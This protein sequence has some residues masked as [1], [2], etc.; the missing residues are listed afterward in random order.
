GRISRNPHRSSAQHP[1]V[2]GPGVSVP[3]RQRR[4]RGWQ[5]STQLP[6]AT[7]GQVRAALGRD[8]GA[9]R[10]AVIGVVLV[11]GLASAAALVGPWL[12]GLII[13]TVQAEPDDVLG[14]VDRLALGALV[15]TVAQIMLR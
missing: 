6:V 10:A 9:D 14:A 8:L 5:M 11:N 3:E 15:F 1:F 4:P 12:L 7:P 13:D 2:P